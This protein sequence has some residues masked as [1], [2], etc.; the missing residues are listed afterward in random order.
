MEIEKEEEWGHKTKKKSEKGKQKN[1]SNKNSKKKSGEKK[2]SG[3]KKKSSEKKKGEKKKKKKSVVELLFSIHE[4][5]PSHAQVSQTAV[6]RPEPT[7]GTTRP[8]FSEVK[9]HK[10]TNK[11]KQYVRLNVIRRSKRPFKTD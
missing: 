7:W 10:Q 6:I 4:E 3:E 11:Q 2:N 8:T 9:I 1:N 5:E